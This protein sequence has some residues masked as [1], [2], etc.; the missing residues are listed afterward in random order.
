MQ[1][2]SPG[3]AE[4]E[5]R[6]YAPTHRLKVE[7]EVEEK[8]LASSSPVLPAFGEASRREVSSAASWSSK[9]TQEQHDEQRSTEPLPREAS[10]PLDKARVHLLFM[11]YDSLPNLDIWARFLSKAKRG[12]DY[13]ALLHCKHYE[14]CKSDLASSKHGD[15]LR[16][17]PTVPSSWCDD[18]VAPMDALL[19]EGLALPSAGKASSGGAPNDKFVFLSDTTVPIKSFAEVQRQLTIADGTNSNFCI[20]PQNAWAWHREAGQHRDIA[21]KHHQWLILSREHAAEALHAKGR[22]Q[23]FMKDLTPLHWLGTTWLAPVIQDGAKFITR[24][25]F[26]GPHATGCLDEFLYF[27]RLF[28][29]AKPGELEMT[30][31]SLGGS[32]VLMEG[33]PAEDF[34]GVCNTFDTFGT[35]AS[36][37]DLVREFSRDPD[38]LLE[39]SEPERHPARFIQL[40][41]SGLGTLR[42]SPFLFARK[43]DKHTTYTGEMSAAEAFQRYVFEDDGSAAPPLS[44][45]AVAKHAEFTETAARAADVFVMGSDAE[46][47]VQ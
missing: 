39:L 47:S 24:G 7:L 2:C 3:P 31:A 27:A 34:Q 1:T 37:Q 4:E 14:K 23:S 5:A 44:K 32:P 16:L 42:R 41:P 11:A 45:E 29:Y 12:E 46:P 33:Q 22:W 26:T 43:V 6:D 15:M 20:T 40:S 9:P 19:E 38:T 10:V 18:L 30:R 25:H 8:G 13:E 36:F 17:V 21:L 35:G 28:G